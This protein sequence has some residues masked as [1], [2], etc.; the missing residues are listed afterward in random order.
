[1]THSRM[2]YR[3][4]SSRFGQMAR[5]IQ[6]IDGSIRLTVN[7]KRLAKVDT[8]LFYCHHRTHQSR[9]EWTLRHQLSATAVGQIPKHLTKDLETLVTHLVPDF[10]WVEVSFHDSRVTGYLI[11][12]PQEHPVTR[13]PAD[14]TEQPTVA[15]RNRKAVEGA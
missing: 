13:K 10:G 1:M 14:W 4:L 15:L 3:E 6:L 2:T 8:S 9:D 7:Q 12:V 5:S 11:H